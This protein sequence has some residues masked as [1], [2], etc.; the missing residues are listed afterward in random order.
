MSGSFCPFCGNEIEFTHLGDKYILRCRSCPE[1]RYHKG[2]DRTLKERLE[3]MP[4]ERRKLTSY[5]QKNRSKYPNGLNLDQDVYD[6]LIF[7]AGGP[8]EPET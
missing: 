6:D 2:F 3:K 4:Q 7:Q 5:L 1:L 8:W